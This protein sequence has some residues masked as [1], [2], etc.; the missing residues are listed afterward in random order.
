MTWC[1]SKRSFL[2]AVA[3]VPVLLGSTFQ[4]A[5]AG[6]WAQPKGQYYTKISSSIYRSDELFNAVGDRQPI[7]IYGS[8]FKANQG[9]LYVEYGVLDRLTLIGQLSGAALEQ[10]SKIR[11]NLLRLS[12]SGVGDLVLGAKYQLVGAPIVF[13]PSLK[14]KIPTSY[15]DDLTPALGTGSSDVELGAMAARSLYPLPLY[16]GV[17]AGYRV[18]GGPFSNQ[19]SAGAELGSRPLSRLFI[20]ATLENSRTLNGNVGL[21]DSGIVQVSDGG[22]TKLGLITGLRIGRLLWLELSFDSVVAGEEVSAGH[23][24][25]VGLSHSH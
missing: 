24:W 3:A 17:E 5:W 12:T 8:D 14:V 6:A 7:S 20:K 9:F 13:S 15:D 19:I 18:R 4:A 1:M 23:S 16:V 22:F 21:S 25:G 10:E 2:L 11:H